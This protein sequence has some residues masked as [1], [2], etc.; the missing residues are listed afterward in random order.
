MSSNVDAEGDAFHEWNSANVVVGRSTYTGALLA[1]RSES[2]AGHRSSLKVS[3]KL[4]N[5]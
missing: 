1:G 3:S 4:V 2:L 5:V